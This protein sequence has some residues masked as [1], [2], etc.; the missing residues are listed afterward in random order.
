[1]R[2]N[3]MA[4]GDVGQ[5]LL[6]GLKLLGEDIID[7]IG[8]YDLN[9]AQIDRLEME[10]GQIS[11]PSSDH[12]LPR[13]FAIDEENLLSC[14]ILIFCATKGVPPVGEAGDV[15]MMQLAANG[16]IISELGEKIKNAASKLPESDDDTITESGIPGL[17]LVM[18]DP[19][20]KLCNILLE[21]SGLHPERI[22]GLGLGV[23]NARARYFAER[24]ERFATYS[25]DGRVFG[26]HGEDLV[27]ANSVSNYDDDISRELT[28]LVKS[29][30]MK[31]RELGFKPYIAPAMSS[32]AISVIEM[33]KGNW[34][35]G[36]VWLEN[37]FG[38]EGKSYF[39]MLSRLTEDGW[40]LEEAAYP[41]ELLERL[42]ES[43]EKGID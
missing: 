41:P 11:Y 35:Y 16:E 18:S 20:D 3:I 14:D 34:T 7:E 19:V 12:Q 10:M 15:R 25:F 1:M 37:P 42:R 22:R 29:A 6:L 33:L 32:G 38:A 5:N 24:D 23:M 2:I 17:I 36:S 39:G 30:N 31:V 40:E 4:L 8:I 43:F 27:V 9:G 28:E 13:V 26:P 21:T